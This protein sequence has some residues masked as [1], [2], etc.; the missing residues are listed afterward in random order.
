MNI[1]ESILENVNEILSIRDTLGAKK[2]DVYLLTR[3]WYKEIGQGTPK[4]SIVQISPTPFIFDVTHDYKIVDGGMV[5]IGD[6]MLKH[7]SKQ[8]Y[9]TENLINCEVEDPT[10]Q[11]KFYYMNQRLYNVV[12]VSESY[13]YWNLL[14]RKTHNQ[15][16]YL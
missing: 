11:E 5:K 14:V 12:N 9:P 16:V 3:N 2:Y 1:V 10:K 8:S 7:L 13:V 6:I 4:D 15:K